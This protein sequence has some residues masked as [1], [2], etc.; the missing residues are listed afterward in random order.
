MGNYFLRVGVSTPPPGS[1]RKPPRYLA[2]L[3]GEGGVS[4]GC[5]SRLPRHLTAGGLHTYRF[6]SAARLWLWFHYK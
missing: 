3:W 2:H 6:Y 4:E 5:K 1:S